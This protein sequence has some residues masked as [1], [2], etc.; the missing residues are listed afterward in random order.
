M[1]MIRVERSDRASSGDLISVGPQQNNKRGHD[2]KTDRQGSDGRAVFMS[3]DLSLNHV[4]S[5]RGF[6][7]RVILT[8]FAPHVDVGHHGECRRML[9]VLCFKCGQGGHLRGTAR[10]NIGAS[11]FLGHAEQE[12]DASGVSLH[13][14]KLPRIPP[15]RD[16]DGGVTIELIPGAE[17][18]SKAPYR[19]APIELKELKDQLQELLERGFIR[20]SV[21][22]WGAPVLFV[23]KKDG[24]MRMIIE[25]MRTEALV[26]LLRI[27]TPTIQS[28]R[29]MQNMVAECFEFEEDV[30]RS[31]RNTF[32]GVVEERCGVVCVKVFNLSVAIVSDRDPRFS[33][34]LKGLQK[35]WGPG[36]SLVQLFIP[37]PIRQ[38]VALN[39]LFRDVVWEKLKEARLSSR[40]VTPTGIRRALELQQGGYKYHPLTL[41]LSFDQFD[42]IKKRRVRSKE[43]SGSLIDKLNLKSAENEDFKTQIQDKVF[44]I[45]SLKNDLRKIKGKEIV[46]I[47]A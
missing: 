18:I 44:V 10:R 45:T 46:D 33:L 3:P 13:L 9:L 38:S 23:K 31:Q 6:P 5:S 12:A 29:V 7:L 37:R 17:P 36:S 24:S 16:D 1:T 34:V 32:G 20:P 41:F 26:E 19:M 30:S 42:S 25:I 14:V 15:I 47:A 2:Q 28:I 35:A 27:M 8:L 40:R 43:Q 11:A 21:S 4:P 22:P 39:A